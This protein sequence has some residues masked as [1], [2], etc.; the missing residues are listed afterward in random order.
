MLT[1]AV[2]KITWRLLRDVWLV[3]LGSVLAINEVVISPP[4]DLNALIFAAA[5]L[6]IAGALRQDEK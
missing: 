1:T 6:G 4:P 3:C 5:C 2:G